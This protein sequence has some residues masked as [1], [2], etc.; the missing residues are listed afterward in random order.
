[1]VS[2]IIGGTQSL[3]AEMALVL[4]DIFGVPAEHFMHLQK[5]YELAQAR[6][7]SRPDPGRANRAVLFGALPVGEM[8]K[9]GWLPGV[10]AVTNV[11][12]AERALAKFFGVGSA[13]EIE[14]MPH[15]AKKTNI[16]SAATPT[17]L[18]WLYRVRQIAAEM[19][20]PRYSQAA[21]ES[22][23]AKL[24]A[25]RDSP[26]SAR[27]VPRILAE[28]GIRFVIVESLPGAKI[29]GVCLWLDDS[30][31]VIGMSLRYDRI[32]NFWFVL[33][34]EL[35]H[36]RLKHGRAEIMLDAE[37]EGDSAGTGA[38]I[39]EEER[40][41][42]EAASEFCVPKRSMKAF[43]ERKA[44]TF[45]DRDLVGLSRSLGIHPGL[46]AGQLQNYTKRF[47]HFRAHLVKIRHA[48]APS[49]YV[50]GWGDIYPVEP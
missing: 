30:K 41:A 12:E 45:A 24:S 20:T 15:S 14:I 31:P 39:A 27:K 3:T 32:D 22:A 7:V 42:N 35:E 50:D 13:D 19:L 49:A 34:H 8:I 1:M 40:L 29:D 36:V 18:A 47:E 4:S 10:V 21:V 25:L 5:K 48:V 44:P 28:S 11:P 46:V 33:R 17:Q 9:R 23:I 16:A 43:I 38:D 37:L 6:I 2:K 26:E